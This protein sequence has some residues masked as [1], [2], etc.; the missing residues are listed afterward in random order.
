[1]SYFICIHNYLSDALAQYL[2]YSHTHTGYVCG[3]VCNTERKDN[4][5]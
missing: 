2:Y 5:D 4:F 3:V 1:M